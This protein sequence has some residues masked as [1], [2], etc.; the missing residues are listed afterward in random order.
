MTSWASLVYL[1]VSGLLLAQAD[2]GI[3]SFSLR[4]LDELS[5]AA[6]AAAAVAAVSSQKRVNADCQ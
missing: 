4:S 1:M 6:A 2:E 3:V 5:N